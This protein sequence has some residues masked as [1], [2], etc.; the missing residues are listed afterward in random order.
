MLKSLGRL[1]WP[2]NHAYVTANV[3]YVTVNVAD[4]VNVWLRFLSITF[5][6]SVYCPGSMLCSGS[7]FSITTCDAPPVTALIVFGVLEN[8][9]TGAVLGDHV[10]HRAIRLLGLLI[11]F[12]V[13]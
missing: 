11:G 12:E 7:S 13:I 4:G 9:L 3:A 1:T 5:I 6:F 10:F 8:L 2:A